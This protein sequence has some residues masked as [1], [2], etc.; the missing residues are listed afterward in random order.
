MA[1]KTTIGRL[2]LV[3]LFILGGVSKFQDPSPTAKALQEGYLKTDVK[4]K[5]LTGSNLPLKPSMVSLY[6]Q[7]LIYLT[8]GL[9]L[10][11][12]ILTI[13][14][15]KLGNL[16]LILLLV[17]FNIVIHNPLYAQSEQQF[18]NEVMQALLNLGVMG[19][20]IMGM[21]SSQEKLKTE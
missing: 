20:L 6:S 7:Q 12:A 1:F 4:F 14:G 9:E 3:F 18:H 15:N 10:V 8:G 19:G 21:S 13:L 17:A 5:E 11:G 2:C 16:L